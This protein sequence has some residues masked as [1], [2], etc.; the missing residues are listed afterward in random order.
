MNIIGYH[1]YVEFK[2]IQMTLFTKWKETHIHRKQTYG[3]Q[4]GKVVGGKRR[5]L[6]VTLTYYYA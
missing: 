2:K 4:R 3:H 6:G 1:L 5:S